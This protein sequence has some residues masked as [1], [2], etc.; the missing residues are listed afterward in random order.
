MAVHL[1]RIPARYFNYYDATALPAH[2]RAPGRR[3]GPL[4][5]GPGGGDAGLLR[6][7]STPS[8][9]GSGPAWCA[10][11]T[12]P[13]SPSSIGRRSTGPPCSSST[14]GSPSGPRPAARG[15]SRAL[16]RSR[17]G[18][19]RRRGRGEPGP[20]AHGRPVGASTG[21]AGTGR[22]IG[23][24]AVLATSFTMPR[25]GVKRRACSRDGGRRGPGKP[26]LW[27]L[28]RTLASEV[29]SGK[30]TNADRRE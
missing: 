19:E 28:A 18:S 4:P 29:G 14:G 25:C 20:R 17:S 9:P 23:R 27:F 22:A 13:T 24:R 3:Q 5:R 21:S 8:P 12:R 10:G 6:C 30:W 1:R 16:W 11:A 2:V 15:R 26:R 7:S